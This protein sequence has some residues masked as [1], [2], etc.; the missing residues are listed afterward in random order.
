[1]NFLVFVDLFILIFRSLFTKKRIV[2][3]LNE[4]LCYRFKSRLVWSYRNKPNMAETINNIAEYVYI[5]MILVNTWLKQSYFVFIV[6]S[7]HESLNK[8]VFVMVICFRSKRKL[9][10]LLLWNISWQY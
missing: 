2:I 9:R 5:N 1:M 8:L 6:Q 7:F 10:V 3:S 4:F